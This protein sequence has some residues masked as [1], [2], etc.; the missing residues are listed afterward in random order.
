MRRDHSYRLFFMGGMYVSSVQRS[1]TSWI[2]NGRLSTGNTAYKF[3]RNP[4]NN[5]V[6]YDS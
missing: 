4:L 2:K 5:L 6:I 1:V 3:N